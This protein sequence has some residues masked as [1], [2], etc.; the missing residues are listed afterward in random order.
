MDHVSRE[1]SSLADEFF[2]PGRLALA[3]QY[4]DFLATEG[5]LRGLIGPR[6]APRL[7]SRHLLNCVAIA[8]LIPQGSTV[9]DV[10]SGAGLPGLVLAIA[11]EDLRVTLVEPLLRR[12]AFLEEVVEL[13]GLGDSVDVVRGRA[14]DLHGARR[15]T[16]VTARAVAPL[17]RLLE[18]CMPLVEASGS[19]IALKGSSAEVEIVEAAPVLARLGCGEP[20]V[21]RVGIPESTTLA[22]RV[23]WGADVGIGWPLAS[24][25]SEA[26]SRPTHQRRKRDR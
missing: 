10:G 19:L 22:V 14:Q 18:W 24:G 25:A 1:T 12:T 2:G 7:W 3:D 5:V 16:I 20:E 21:L 9:C 11:R 8:P 15:F 26:V 13:L 23:A 4:A 6:E 17:G